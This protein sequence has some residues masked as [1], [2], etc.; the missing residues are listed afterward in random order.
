MNELLHFKCDL[1]GLSIT[2]NGEHPS[3]QAILDK[4]GKLSLLEYAFKTY[5]SVDKVEIIRLIKDH[6]KNNRGEV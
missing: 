5:K 2:I 6:K 4:I 1:A 3:R